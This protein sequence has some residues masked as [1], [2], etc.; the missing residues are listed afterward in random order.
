MKILL[1]NK[2]KC[3]RTNSTFAI[4]YELFIFFKVFVNVSHFAQANAKT[5][6]CK[7]AI[8]TQHAGEVEESKN[9]A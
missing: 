3:H 8:F 5:Q 9:N 6:N 4:T 2:G 1:A 7:R